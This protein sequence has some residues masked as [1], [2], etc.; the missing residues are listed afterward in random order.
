MGLW[1][2]PS[3]RPGRSLSQ[4]YD[5]LLVGGSVASL[6]A[7]AQLARNGC[8]TALVDAGNSESAL[9]LGVVWPGLA[10]H[11][12]VLLDAIGQPAC[13]SLLALIQRSVDI[14]SAPT[15]A[16]K[17]GATLQLANNAP[18]WAEL[19]LHL[20]WVNARWPRRLMSGGSASNYLTVGDVAGAAFVQSGLCFDP[21]AARAAL[22][23]ECESAGVD[24]C[25]ATITAAGEDAQGAWAELE[26]QRVRSEVQVVGAG[27]RTLSLLGI[28]RPWLFPLR[29]AA[30]R[31]SATGEPWNQGLAALESYRGHL[32]GRPGAAAEEWVIGGFNP[33]AS[34]EAHTAE[35]T[36]DTALTGMIHKLTGHLL[37][38]LSAHEPEATCP[39]IYSF[40]ADG[41]PLVGPLPGSQRTWLVAGFAGRSWSLGPAIG[42][43]VA[44]ALL[45]QPHDLLNS[46]PQFRP[47][48]WMRKD[49][50]TSR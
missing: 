48:R 29:G 12:G 24:V 19:S 28:E 46:L 14:L 49:A 7:A 13:E 22:L 27:H 10:E 35:Q 38:A 15:F 20:D 1:P 44:R 18:E 6:F 47:A 16:A 26:G 30:L 23:A 9:D 8:R 33:G 17:R 50:A 39:L 41:L 21:A 32:M 5:V 45:Q 3:W 2:A 4:E 43:E 42:E 37:P 25:L 36:L 11:W 40:S 31:Y 34:W